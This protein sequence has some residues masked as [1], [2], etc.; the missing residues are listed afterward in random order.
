[1]GGNGGFAGGGGGGGGGGVAGTGGFGAGNGY[2]PGGGGA[3]LGGA[4]FNDA[5]GWLTL[6]NSTLTNNQALAGDGGE[7]GSAYGAAVFSRDGNVT[8]LGSTIYSNALQSGESINSTPGS[9]GGAVYLYNDLNEAHVPELSLNYTLIAQTYGRATSLGSW[10]LTTSCDNG[11]GI[12]LLGGYNALNNMG[13]CNILSPQIALADNDPN[14]VG[15]FGYYGGYTPVYPLSPLSPAIDVSVGCPPSLT[16]DQRGIARPINGSCDIGS[17]EAIAGQFCTGISDG[18]VFYAVGTTIYLNAAGDIHCL[19][20]EAIP[21][22]HPQASAGLQTGTYWRIQALNSS[23]LPAAG[24]T[25]E[26]TLP[27]LNLPSPSVCKWVNGPGAGWDCALDSSTS[28]S[29]TRQNITSFSD[30]AVGS[31]VGPTAVQ[32]HAVTAGQPSVLWLSLGLLLPL[33]L[34][35]AGFLKRHLR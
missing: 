15:S 24:Y 25:A 2:G 4:I 19:F 13:S 34:I 31:A 18:A 10:G 5:P 11:N 21:Q 29:A 7:G 17:Y 26:L 6:V 27:H 1:M 22:S 8:I 23:G 35:S 33:L 14:V 32:L 20:I 12:S 3:A 16:V 28:A 30:W 9:F